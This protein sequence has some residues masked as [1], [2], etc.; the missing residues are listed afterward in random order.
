MTTSSTAMASSP[1]PACR[2]KLPLPTA[3]VI[4]MARNQVTTAGPGGERAPIAGVGAAHAGGQ[5]GEHEDRLQPL[6]QD[7]DAAV[8]DHGGSP[9]P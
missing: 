1:V 6:A 5:H 9:R 4:A 7:E 3:S 8:D 2:S